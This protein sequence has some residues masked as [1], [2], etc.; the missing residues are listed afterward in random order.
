[1]NRWPICFDIGDEA[2]ARAKFRDE[3]VLTWDAT[4][5][6]DACGQGDNTWAIT[7]ACDVRARLR[8]IKAARES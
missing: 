7:W 4:D 1:M 6:A 3:P 5:S 2:C 8:R